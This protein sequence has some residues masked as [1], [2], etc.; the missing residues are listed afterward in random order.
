M[1]ANRYFTVL[2]QTQC[3][4]LVMRFAGYAIQIR[5]MQLTLALR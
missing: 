1:A 4:A 3:V 2:V 5:K